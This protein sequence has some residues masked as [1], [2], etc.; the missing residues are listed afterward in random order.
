MCVPVIESDRTVEN[1]LAELGLLLPE[2]PRPVGSY[3]AAVIAND[4][5]FISGQIPL[6]DGELKYPGRVGAELSEA[7]HK[8]IRDFL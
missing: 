7:A 3:R 5:L 6:L 1:R 4:L 2:A 8:C